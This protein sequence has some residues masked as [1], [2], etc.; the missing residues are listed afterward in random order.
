MKMRK[1]KGKIAWEIKKSKIRIKL[2]RKA[3]RV[4]WVEN[5]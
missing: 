1:N 4:K 5:R 3:K 2:V